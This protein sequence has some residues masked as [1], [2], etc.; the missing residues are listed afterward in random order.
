MKIK[1]FEYVGKYGA[2]LDYETEGDYPSRMEDK[3]W[4]LLG[5]WDLPEDFIEKALPSFY[6]E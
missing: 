4:E 3:D 1:I 2:G 5:E 6:I